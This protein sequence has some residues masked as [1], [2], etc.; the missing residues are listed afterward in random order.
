MA[1][2]VLSGVNTISVNQI[3]IV[4]I[5]IIALIAIIIIVMQWRRVRESQNN[6]RIM[7]TEIE[8]KK[9]SMVEKD[10]ESKRLMENPI[11][12]PK[13]QQENLST[14]RKSTSDIMG[15]V[16][17]LHSEIN[18]RLARLEAQTEQKKLEKMLKEIEIKEKQLLKKGKL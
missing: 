3:F 18:E 8:L 16:G 17:Y 2:V 5:A 14:I 4:V 9:I 11:Q 12:L 15:D 1:N 7:E 10:L 13:E 6:V